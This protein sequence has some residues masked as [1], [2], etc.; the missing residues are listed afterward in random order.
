[1]TQAPQRAAEPFELQPL[2]ARS[3]LLSVLLGTHPPALPVRMLVRTV[4]LFG[5]SEG[6]ARVALSRLVSDG[7]VVANQACYRLSERLIERQRAQDEALRPKTRPWRGRWELA[8]A[9][10][11]IRGAGEL[12]ALDGA[13]RRL[14]LAELRPGVWGR[15]DNLLRSWPAEISERVWRIEADA[16]LEPPGSARLAAQLWDP[17]GWAAT[18]EALIRSMTATAGASRRFELAAAMVRHIRGDPMLPPS[19]L[20]RR[21]PGTR[22]RKVYDAYRLELHEL[23][24]VERQ[25]Q[26]GKEMTGVPPDPASPSPGG[27]AD[28]RPR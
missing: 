21:W 10:P 22:L 7:E 23:I 15:P 11:P 18:A 14:R 19:L 17:Q 16:S 9:H 27:V 24:S 3:V 2:T 1:M 20:P 28:R 8:V 5:V 12:S 13:L 4:A 25:R 26:S 6:T